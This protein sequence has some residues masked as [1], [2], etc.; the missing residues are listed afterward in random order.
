MARQRVYDR[1]AAAVVETTKRAAIRA[2]RTL[3]GEMEDIL[4]VYMKRHSLTREQAEALLKS[5]ADAAT[6]QALQSEI[7]ATTDPRARAFL[8]AR[9]E[10]ASYSAR[11]TRAQAMQDRIVLESAH[12]A[13]VE[14]AALREHLTYTYMDG[15]NRF[16]Y[17]ASRGVGRMFE[18][19]APSIAQAGEVLLHRWAG[20]NY[21]ARV[22]G[23]AAYMNQS[24][25]TAL[26]ENML[27]GETS[28]ETWN[29]LVEAAGG[30][31]RHA[32]RLIRTETAYIAGQAEKRGY[33]A[34]GYEEY[35]F[36]ARLEARTCPVCGKLDGQRFAVRDAVAGKNL[37]PIH[38]WCRCTT[39]PWD[40]IT[41]LLQAGETRWAKD[42]ET[43]EIIE[44]PMSMTYEEWQQKYDELHPDMPLYR[45]RDKIYRRTADERMWHEYQAVAGKENI[46][47]TLDEFQ[48]LKYNKSS[49]HDWWLTKGYVKGIRDQHL[50]AL[51]GIET[52]KA[53]DREIQQ[54]LVGLTTA[55]GI[56]I[57]GYKTHFIDRVIGDYNDEN[58]KVRL[59]VSVN[60]VLGC[61]T[62]YAE[63][64]E[65]SRKGILSR[66]Y[67]CPDCVVTINPDTRMLIQTNPRRK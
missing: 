3:K 54:K 48:N 33:Q 7:A 18:Y 12:V 15:V 56:R 62:G 43:G 58:R 25:Q 61:L 51:T 34:A 46:P 65:S 53:V 57:S 35:R 26:M 5:P 67:L 50:S 6:R 39:E 27:S 16:M 42:P 60:S 41:A 44:V 63:V 2:L 30:V 9:I 4:R 45:Q 22:W 24:L 40:D 13:Q 1:S 31:V 17:D 38:P 64:K 55:D 36:V 10:A 21:S 37:P 52:Y 29:A 49:Q 23:N 32:E 14:E 19:A 8:R 11:L 47:K 59:G 66:T 20:G 28:E